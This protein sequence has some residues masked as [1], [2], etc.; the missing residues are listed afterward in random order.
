MYANYTG[1][2]LYLILQKLL[3]LSYFTGVSASFNI[4]SI[5]SQLYFS[6][7][8]VFRQSQL[9]I[10]LLSLLLFGLGFQRKYQSKCC[11][12]QTEIY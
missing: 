2:E 3:R 5:S 9:L 6:A 11:Q 1:Q 4:F 12:F 8:Q 10:S 7:V